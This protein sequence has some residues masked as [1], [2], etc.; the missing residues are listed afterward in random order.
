MSGDPEEVRYLQFLPQFLIVFQIFRKERRKGIPPGGLAFI[1][2]QKK[3]LV[4]VDTV[5]AIT[6]LSC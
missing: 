5:V 3:G 4:H 6:H 2:S 1:K